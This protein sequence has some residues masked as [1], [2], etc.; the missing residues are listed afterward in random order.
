MCR[1]SSLAA[2]K[3]Y[4]TIDNKDED[5]P[6]AKEPSTEP[7]TY[8]KATSTETTES[9][10]E[11]TEASTGEKK[12]FWEIEPKEQKV[13]SSPTRSSP[14]AKEFRELLDEL[15]NRSHKEPVVP[16]EV[17]GK[18]PNTMIEQKLL[19]LVLR[20]SKPYKKRSPLPNRM[21]GL[22]PKEK[23]REDIGSIFDFLNPNDN[24]NM[25]HDESI[26][27]KQEEMR[28]IQAIIDS[29][30]DIELLDKVQKEIDREE[31]HKYYPRVIG[32]AIEHAAR[33]DP[34][35]ALTL[36]EMVKNKSITS[37]IFGCTTHVYNTLL[38]LHWTTWGDIYGMLDL[39]EEMTVNGIEF[40]N[41]SRRIVR[42]AVNEIESEGKTDTLFWNSDEKTCGNIMKEMAGKWLK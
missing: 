27:L 18:R 17:P 7:S 4:S 15:F 3:Q 36:F 14:G 24:K 26:Q 9:T 29:K 21:Y 40:D 28:T 8:V 25:V 12:F 2:F 31:Y 34:Y 20:D 30:T 5:V 38:L 23:E 1:Q 22:E 11:S 19:Q 37:Y 16:V 39:M 41:E 35:L 32:K 42:D 6:N 13:E 10:S 33:K